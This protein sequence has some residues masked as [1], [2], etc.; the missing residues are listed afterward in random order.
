[1]QFHYINCWLNWYGFPLCKYLPSLQL[2]IFLIF[3]VL[4]LFKLD[5]LQ[6]PHST[7]HEWC[8]CIGSI[9]LVVQPNGIHWL[10][11]ANSGRN[12]HPV[13]CSRRQNSPLVILLYVLCLY[14]IISPTILSYTNSQCLHTS[15]IGLDTMHIS[16]PPSPSH[17]GSINDLYP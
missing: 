2:S 7:T 10:S 4:L 15:N 9:V 3:Q 11:S 13:H 16:L 6:F 8:T 12:L 1:M 17:I 5:M 14:R